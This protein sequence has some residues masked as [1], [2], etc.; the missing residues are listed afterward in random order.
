MI[1]KSDFWAYFV[2]SLIILML[3]LPIILYKKKSQSLQFSGYQAENFEIPFAI[4]DPDTIFLL[5]KELKEISGM[6]MLEDEKIYA[7]NDEK[8]IL[9]LF[10]LVSG[11]IISEI[12]FGKKNDYEALT[13]YG[14]LIFIAE[15]NGKISVVSTSSKAKIAKHDTPLSRRNDVEGISYDKGGN[16]L[17]LACKGEL[18]KGKS[19]KGKKGIYSFDLAT[20]TLADEPYLLLDIRKELKELKPIN[21]GN[22]IAKKLTVNSRL[23]MFAP[24]GLAIDPLTRQ[25]YVLANKGNMLVV[26]D[27]N[28][29]F[30]GIYFLD[31]ILH[32][33]PEGIVFDKKG[34]LYISN[35]GKSKEANIIRF[36]RKKT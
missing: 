4:S 19:R 27:P 3:A 25:L 26:I 23:N 33:Q 14:N 18:E 24:S 32:N 20:Q 21:I 10:D 29:T 17:L 36:M 11:D 30:Q 16:Q 8:G 35:E 9:Y 31:H 12:D 1:I 15:S 28:K 13:N 2:S 5:P 7:I 34:N 22:N 6:A